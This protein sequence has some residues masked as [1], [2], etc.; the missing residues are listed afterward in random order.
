MA[1][2]YQDTT[3]NLFATV[4]AAMDRA[5]LSAARIGSGSG[6]SLRERGLNYTPGELNLQPPP[7]F[8]DLLAGADNANAITTQIDDKVDQWLA[9]YFPSIN[10]GFKN[11]PEDFV[12]G[13]I[14][15]TKPFGIDSTVFD[16]VWHK[17][18]DRAY[19]TSSSERRTL[20]AAFSGRGFALPVG[21]L[22]DA[23]SQSEQRATDA[24]LDV[25]RDAAIRDAEIKNDILKYSL[26]IAAQL[27]TGILGISAEFFRSYFSVYGLDNETQRIR[28]QA[29]NTYYSALSNYYNVEVAWENLHLRAA[30]TSAGI[31]ADIDR[32]RVANAG[33]RGSAGAHAQAAQGFASI[34]QGAASAAG[35]LT[36][37]IESI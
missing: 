31:S 14:S 21:A 19:R 34:A 27:K 35:S 15:G 30:E 7:K 24:A 29:Y 28:A 32:N 11:Q 8:S 2:N 12:L 17:S 33:Q 23:M 26:G 37:Q 4:T 36:A 25:N 9:T 10:G 18:R 1:S 5:S 3:N 13:V 20:E 6:A 22:V 16:M